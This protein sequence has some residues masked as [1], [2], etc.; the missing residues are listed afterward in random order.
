MK[1]LIFSDFHY[2]PGVFLCSGLEGLRLMQKKAEEQACDFIIQAGDFCHG[3]AEVPELMEAYNNFHIPSYNVLGN[4][5]AEFTSYEETLRY[6]RMPNEYYHFD[7]GGYR[8]IVLNPNYYYDEGEYV[9]FSLANWLAHNPQRDWFPPQ[10][11]QWLEQTIESSPY[12]CVIISHQSLERVD[13]VKNRK[14]ALDIINAANRRKKHSVLMCINGHYHRDNLRILDGVCY[15]DLNGASSDWIEKRHHCYPDELH[16]K[17]K[18]LHH[19]IVN[20]S[21]LYAVIEL[22]GSSIDIRG[23]ETSMLHGI[24]YR[25]ATGSDGYDRCGR[26]WTPRIQSAKLTLE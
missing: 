14:E 12:P 7:V 22:Q 17:V 24:A 21:P 4:H 10:Q 18:K 26:P 20:E 3:A 5:D 6:Y 13:G 19:L 11:L 9:H 8:I 16:E 25:D 2:Q 1:F 15:L 23:S